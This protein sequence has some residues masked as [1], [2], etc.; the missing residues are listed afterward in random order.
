MDLQPD[1]P[2]GATKRLAHFTVLGTTRAQAIA[3]ANALVTNTG[4]GGEAAAFLTAQELA[5]LANF[6][7]NTAPTD[8]SLSS[9]AIAENSGTNAVI[10]TLSFSDSNPG[11]TAVFSLPTGLG[12]NSLFNIAPDGVTLRANSS[13]NFEATNAYSVTVRVTDAGGLAFD[14]VIVIG[15]IDVNEAPTALILTPSSATLSEDSD[16]SLAIDLATIAIQ[17]RRARQ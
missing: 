14:K 11:D 16:T 9:N 12:N 1:G 4:F 5:S 6:E 10:G 3:S 17:R 15:V 7:F 13:F 8:L 2:A